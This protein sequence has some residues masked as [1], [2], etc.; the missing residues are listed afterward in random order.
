LLPSFLP[1]FLLILLLGMGAAGD[2][3]ADQHV[4]VSF[5]NKADKAFGADTDFVFTSLDSC[6]YGSVKSILANTEFKWGRQ[7]WHTQDACLTNIYWLVFSDSDDVKSICTDL[8]A[9]PSVDYA[10]ESGTVGP[11]ADPY[12]IEPNDY[13]YNHSFRWELEHHHEG[14]DD[15]QYMPIEHYRQWYLPLLGLQRA[16]AITTGDSSVVVAI[17]DSGFDLD[18][19]DL[20][21]VLWWNQAELNGIHGVDD[22]GNGLVDDM[23]GWDFGSAV[24]DETD[25]TFV[26]TGD[27]D[28]TVEPHWWQLAGCASSCDCDY[29]RC[30]SPGC[31]PDHCYPEYWGAQRHGL[32]MAGIIS[33]SSND[34]SGVAGINWK[35][36][37]LPIKIGP[38]RP[39]HPWIDV[40]DSTLWPN[41]IEAIN[42]V[43]EMKAN[44][45]AG[46]PDIH[47]LNMSLTFDRAGFENPRPNPEPVFSP[48]FD[49]LREY[50][51]LPVGGSGNSA[52]NSSHLHPVYPCR[53]PNV[54]CAD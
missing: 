28:V 25:S 34:S 37:I 42:Y 1:S 17:I 27:N 20:K 29:C 40:S 49:R 36:K 7:L 4:I 3:A 21:D 53:D 19:P 48:M 38:N 5:V 50:G 52:N 51:I 18:H 35:T 31:D 2:S 43:C 32:A 33:A 44:A 24:Y 11:L 39:T 41:M 23:C 46:S 6:K 16:W 30:G 22:D 45:A 15:P 13:W 14:C 9:D 47:V 54:L 12:V 10:T 26:T 8:E